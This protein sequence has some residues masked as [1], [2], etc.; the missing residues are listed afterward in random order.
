[1]A[2][3]KDSAIVLRRLDY[4]ETSQVLAVFT[5]AHGQLRLIAKGI[6]RGTKDRAGI[7][8]DLLELGD[9]VFSLRPGKE[10]NLATLTE[11]RQRDGHAHLRQD[12]G[13]MYAAQYAAEATAHLTELHDPHPVL[14]DGM[15]ALLHRLKE[16]GTL[17]RLVEYLLL[18]LKE[19][20]LQPEWANCVN[21]GRSVGGDPVA[22]FSSRQGGVVCRDCE[23]ALVEKRRVRIETLETCRAGA[24]T[25]RG[26]VPGA[27]DLLDYYLRETAGRPLHLSSLLRAVLGLATLC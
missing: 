11:W 17:S 2:L 25:V 3:V 22:Y 24:G 13:R 14:F 18:L 7:C 4:S 19:I 16:A 27:F 1:M 26:D 6:K 21:C 8:I 9:A 15:A 20:G 12:L 5:R 23:A 10:S